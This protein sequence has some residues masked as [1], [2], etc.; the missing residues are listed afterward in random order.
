MSNLENLY[1]ECACTSDEHLV[2]I[3]CDI[4]DKHPERDSNVYIN[5]QLSTYLPWYKRVVRAVRYVFGYECKYGHWD[6]A[7]LNMEQVG[8]LHMFLHAFGKEVLAKT[9]ANQPE[10]AKPDNQ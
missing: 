3:T 7:M 2:R 9:Q 5:V 10:A 6:E 4:D 1:V 8:K